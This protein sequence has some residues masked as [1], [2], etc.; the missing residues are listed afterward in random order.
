M[1][2]LMGTGHF[3]LKL[4]DV[5]SIECDNEKILFNKKGNGQSVIIYFKPNYPVYITNI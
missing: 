4:K 3:E 1:S 2:S 5:D